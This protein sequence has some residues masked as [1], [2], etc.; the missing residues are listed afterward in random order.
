MRKLW[1]Q[2]H[3][4][5]QNSPLNLVVA[6]Y[7]SMDLTP[8]GLNQGWGT[9]GELKMVTSG[10]RSLSSLHA[11]WWNLIWCHGH[12]FPSKVWKLVDTMGIYISGSRDCGTSD[13]VAWYPLTKTS[14]FIRVSV[15][16]S[17]LG[18]ETLLL[19]AW[20]LSTKDLRCCKEAAR[21]HATRTRLSGH[22]WG[23]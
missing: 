10:K 19:R 4:I 22:D 23:W 16:K 3:E 5:S 8:V 7:D 12:K 18:T 13:C 6:E 17:S 9:I 11:F 15:W 14:R 20:S 2:V 21:R 1:D